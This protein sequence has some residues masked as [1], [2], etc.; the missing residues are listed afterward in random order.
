MTMCQAAIKRESLHR[1]QESSATVQQIQPLASSM[2]VSAAGEIAAA[3]QYVRIDADI[4]KF[5]MMRARRRPL[6]FSSSG[7]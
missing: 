2:I 1:G 7:E 3:I 6:E 5:V 4:A